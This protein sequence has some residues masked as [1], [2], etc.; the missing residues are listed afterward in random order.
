MTREEA[1]KRANEVRQG[2][3]KDVDDLAAHFEGSV[4][5]GQTEIVSA[6]LPMAG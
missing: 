5:S 2:I 4:K 3:E 6:M 1:V